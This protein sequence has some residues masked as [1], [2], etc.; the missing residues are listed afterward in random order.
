[1]F[2]LG[3]LSLAAQNFAE[4]FGAFDEIGDGVDELLTPTKVEMES[5]GIGVFLRHLGRRS[6]ARVHSTDRIG[7]HFGEKFLVLGEL[8]DHF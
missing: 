1:V 4:Y 2:T 3:V 6:L 8:R 7:V 5:D